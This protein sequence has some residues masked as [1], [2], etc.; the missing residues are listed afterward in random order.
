MRNDR[1]F[2]GRAV[3]LLTLLMV[4][5]PAPG[6][7][8]PNDHAEISLLREAWERDVNQA[9]VEGVVS[10]YGAGAV[11]LPEGESPL[12]GLADIR[13]WHRRWFG[14][15]GVTYEMDSALLNVGRDVATE[16]WSAEVTVIPDAADPLAI[17]GDVLQFRQ[18][19][20]R[21]YRRVNGHWRIDRETWSAAPAGV[22]P[23]TSRKAAAC[24]LYAC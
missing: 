7:A 23:Y 15:A 21:V 24:R 22:R 4:T 13:R 1:W 19:G 20:F 12:V 8:T 5:I 11:L 2:V 6:A 18:E 14:T 17:G 3:F 16:E 10:L 9:D